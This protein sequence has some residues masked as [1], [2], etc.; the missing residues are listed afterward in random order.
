MASTS[1]TFGPNGIYTATW[2]GV[3]TLTV[4]QTSGG[5][6][7]A[8]FSGQSLADLTSS[9]QFLT[10]AYTPPAAPAALGLVATIGLTGF[11]LQN[12]TPN[13]FS[14]TAPNDGAVHVFGV[15][16][17]KHVT[18]AETGGVISVVYQPVAGGGN[19][20]TQILA[21]SLGTDT[22]GQVGTTVWGIVQPGSTVTVQQ[23][24]ALTAGASTAWAEL[25]AS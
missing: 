18:S 22:A 10:L 23:A 13:L 8:S 24:S 15:V 6:F 2:D 25:W 7:V 17:V 19:H 21:G 1:W 4:T 3:S 14:W 9:P 12:G 20:T 5:A 11:A 16:S